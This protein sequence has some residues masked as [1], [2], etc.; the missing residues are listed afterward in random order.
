M[1][2]IIELTIIEVKLIVY[3]LCHDRRVDVC[4]CVWC[5]SNLVPS[6]LTSKAVA[7]LHI[8]MWYCV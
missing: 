5:Y 7:S 2:I 4:V 6:K 3:A 8:V 1:C